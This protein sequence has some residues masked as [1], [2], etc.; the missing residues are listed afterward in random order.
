MLRPFTIL[1]FLFI[2]LALTAVCVV[3]ASVQPRYATQAG[4]LEDHPF[5][6]FELEHWNQHSPE[7]WRDVMPQVKVEDSIGTR[8]IWIAAGRTIWGLPK[9]LT[10]ILFAPDYRPE[11]FEIQIRQYG[12]PFRCV[13]SKRWQEF[14]DGID[15][16]SGD[17][18]LS[19]SGYDFPTSIMP[20]SLVAN[21]L[22]LG[23][24][25]WLV[26]GMAIYVRRVLRICAGKCPQCAYRHGE[27]IDDGCPECGWNRDDEV[28]AD[29]IPGATDSD[30]RE[31]S[32]R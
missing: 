32:V 10:T 24:G 23:F 15:V 31:S 21:V 16:Q 20:L 5:S 30:R 8:F 9:G 28:H 3:I 12:W 1:V 22:T 7:K 25:S 19:I 29:S 6:K 17:T 14:A 27:N 11:L 4:D 26:V 18:S 2:G 13:Y